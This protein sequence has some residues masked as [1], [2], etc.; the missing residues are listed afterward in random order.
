[1]HTFLQTWWSIP[2]RLIIFRE[3][4]SH[5][6]FI[7]LVT[8]W[9]ASR[10][11]VFQLYELEGWSKPHKLYN[12][13]CCAIRLTRHF[14]ILSASLN[15]SWLLWWMTDMHFCI[16]TH[17]ASSIINVSVFYVNWFTYI[18]TAAKVLN[19][20]ILL[21]CRANNNNLLWCCRDVSQLTSKD[22]SLHS[23]AQY[24]QSA[25]EYRQISAP[26]SDSQYGIRETAEFWPDSSLDHDSL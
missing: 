26:T 12:M 25:W 20:C 4:S 17:K 19:L 2:R 14:R 24:T 10:W 15:A 16:F 8:G 3:T 21:V 7:V 1:M 5:P 11:V 13:P 23:N 9:C 18:I 6:G 22:D